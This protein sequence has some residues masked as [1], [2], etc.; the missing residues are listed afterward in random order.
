MRPQPHP[1]ADFPRSQQ[2]VPRDR[3]ITRSRPQLQADSSRSQQ[4][5]PRDRVIIRSRPQPQ[6]H[7]QP[8][9]ASATAAIRRVG[10]TNAAPSAM[11]TAVTAGAVSRSPR[12]NND[13]A[14]A[15]VAGAA[16]RTPRARQLIR[17]Q[18]R[19]LPTRAAVRVTE[20]A[21]AMARNAAGAAYRAVVAA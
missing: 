7:V 5:A 17:T 18:L 16:Y 12:G 11:T 15:T 3:V 21:H 1:Q 10:Q 6:A 20:S 9:A 4:G 8:P 14:T 13:D 19:H 2:G